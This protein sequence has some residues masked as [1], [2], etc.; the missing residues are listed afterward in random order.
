MFKNTALYE[1]YVQHAI[2]YFYYSQFFRLPRYKVN[3]FIHCTRLPE[4]YQRVR[5]L[6]EKIEELTAGI[7][8]E[9]YKKH[10]VRCICLH[11]YEITDVFGEK[12]S[13]FPDCLLASSTPSFYVSTH[14]QPYYVYFM[15]F[16]EITTAEYTIPSRVL[17]KTYREI[18]QS[19]MKE[20][21]TRYDFIAKIKDGKLKIVFFEKLDKVPLLEFNAKKLYTVAFINE[22]LLR[23]Y[24]EF[25]WKNTTDRL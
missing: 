13:P 12:V 2:E 1:S 20:P 19:T 10:G 9:Q 17:D 4:K 18:V 8:E 3:R 21:Y 6:G 16:R 11:G 24:V 15:S 22:S 14:N 23:R 7:I 5:V 25:T